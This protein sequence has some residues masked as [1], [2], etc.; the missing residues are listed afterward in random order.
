MHRYG[1]IKADIWTMDMCGQIVRIRTIR[2]ER[3]GQNPEGKD[4]LKTSISQKHSW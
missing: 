4:A 2:K 3:R 1:N